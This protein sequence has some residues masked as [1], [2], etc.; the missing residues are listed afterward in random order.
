ML[1]SHDVQDVEGK[2]HFKN[3][4]YF[5]WRIITILWWFLPYINMNWPRCTC[6]PPP[7]PPL[8]PPSPSYSRAPT[9]SALLHASNLPWSSVL[10]MVIYVFQ[11]YFLKSSHPCLLPQNPKVCS[12]HLCLFCCLAYRI[13]V[14]VFLNPIY[15]H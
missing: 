4:M 3:I 7:W 15:M 11:C 5:N 2:V 12:L 6:V 9:L 13:I 8:P 14:I 10:H 1:P